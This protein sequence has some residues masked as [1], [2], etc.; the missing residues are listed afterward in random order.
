MRRGH[1]E[2]Y[3]NGTDRHPPQKGEPQ[4][5]V[6]I[7][8]SPYYDYGVIK[9]SREELEERMTDIREWQ[10]FYTVWLVKPH[11]NREDVVFFQLK[12]IK[13]VEEDER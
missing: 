9:L 3:Y 10:L 12:N 2:T 4:T 5:L 7:F 6:Y 11:S 13:I 1:A 8:S